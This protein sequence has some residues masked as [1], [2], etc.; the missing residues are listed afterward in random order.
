MAD[1][2]IVSLA[3][4]KLAL[5]ITGTDSDDKLTAL[6]DRL[7]EVFERE[8][9]WYFGPSRE[10]VEVMCGTGTPKMFLGWPFLDTFALECRSYVGDAWETVETDDYEQRGRRV[11]RADGYVWTKGY[12]NFRATYNEG[13]AEVPGEIEQLALETISAVWRQSGSE[14]ITS[15]KIGDYSYT[16]AATLRSLPDFDAVRGSYMRLRIGGC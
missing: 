16:L 12:D 5:D 15:E 8:F 7:T 11:V 1:Y 14:G 3:D 6:I 2:A 13:Y 10:R 9:H 4:A